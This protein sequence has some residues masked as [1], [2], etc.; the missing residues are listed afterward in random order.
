LRAERVE[1][2][3]G[4]GVKRFFG[5]AMLKQRSTSQ[6]VSPARAAAR[7]VEYPARQSKGERRGPHSRNGE[8]R[9]LCSERAVV[10][11]RE[12]GGK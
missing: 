11:W 6:N 4:T 1:S 3:G 5:G 12:V 2:T 7:W 9:T 8:R 10:T